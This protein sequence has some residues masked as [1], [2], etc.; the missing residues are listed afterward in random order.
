DDL[1]LTET[2]NPGLTCV[3]QSAYEKGRMAT[4]LLFKMIAGQHCE[5]A[6]LDAHITHR[7]S[8]AK[9]SK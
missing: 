3:H 8:V 1:P 2:L 7:H 4:K 5:S 6:V 9:L